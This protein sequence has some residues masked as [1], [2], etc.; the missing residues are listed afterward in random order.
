[1]L[2]YLSFGE[3]YVDL[4]WITDKVPNNV[5]FEQF[6]EISLF[7]EIPQETEKIWFTRGRLCILDCHLKPQIKQKWCFMKEA[8][9]LRNEHEYCMGSS[10]GSR[11]SG[12]GATN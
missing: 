3:S 9:N 11:L 7:C 2:G 8:F 6:G 1:M 5:L 10:G 4:F 12:W